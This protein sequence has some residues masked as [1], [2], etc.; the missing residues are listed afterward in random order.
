MSVRQAAGVIYIEGDCGVD[1]AE[2]L[3][4]ALLAAPDAKIDWSACGQ[5]HTAL[6][7]LVLMRKG[8]VQSSCGNAWLR[9]WVS[10]A[11][12]KIATKNDADMHFAAPRNRV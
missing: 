8:Q 6:I 5:L 10:P 12:S 7:Q 2:T 3:L 9:Q 1:E 11:G 4:N